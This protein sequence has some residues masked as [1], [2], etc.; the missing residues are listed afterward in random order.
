M[1]EIRLY[2]SG[3]ETSERSTRIDLGNETF[4]LNVSEEIPI[5]MADQ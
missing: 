2:L 4:I 3:F 1:L 5:E